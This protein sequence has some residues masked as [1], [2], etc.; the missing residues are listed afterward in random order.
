MNLFFD[1]L[2]IFFALLPL[3]LRIAFILVHQLRQERKMKK[4]IH[5]RISHHGLL[6]HFQ[7][8]VDNAR[9]M[10]GHA[11]WQLKDSVDMDGTM[12][13]ENVQAIVENARKHLDAMEAF[14]R[15]QQP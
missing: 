3:P 2:I 1:V 13:R 5:T 7:H 10:V 15:E 9:A 4:L 11:E 14:L 6:W 12:H 8:I